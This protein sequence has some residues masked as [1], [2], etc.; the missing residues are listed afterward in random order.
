MSKPQTKHAVDTAT[1]IVCKNCGHQ[2]AGLYCNV[3]GEKVYNSHDKSIGHFFEEALHFLTH[4]EGTFLTTV[5]AIFTRPGKLS[6]DYC[7]GIRKRYFKPLPFFM[8]LVVVYLIF[9]LLN[10]LNMSLRY[11]PKLMVFGDLAQHMIDHKMAAKLLTFDALSDRFSAKSEKVSKLMLITLIPLAALVIKL[12]YP[13]KRKYFFDYLV[14]SAELNSFFLLFTFFIWASIALLLTKSGW[15]PPRFFADGGFFL[16]F[17]FV[18]FAV[19][20]AIAFSRFFT[21][22]KWISIIKTLVFLPFYFFI[23]FMLY[24][25]LLFAVTMLF[26]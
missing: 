3:C 25:F 1:P 19:F 18:V 24:K 12:L 11:Y 4:F 13:K 17:N 5:K 26:I 16:N 22:K 8:L 21:E 20:I 15:F 9:P 10:G 14:L 7:H 6:F 2:F 23:V